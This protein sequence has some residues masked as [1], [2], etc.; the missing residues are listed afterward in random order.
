MKTE[1]WRLDGLFSLYN[2]ENTWSSDQV[3]C[4]KRLLYETLLHLQKD[5]V[6]NLRDW[7]H[8]VRA[9]QASKAYQSISLWCKDP[10]QKCRR[11][12]SHDLWSPEKFLPWRQDQCKVHYRICT[13]EVPKEE[14]PAQKT[15]LRSLCWNCFLK[16]QQHETN[17]VLFKKSLLPERWPL[18]CKF[19]SVDAAPT[20]LE[21][22]MDLWIHQ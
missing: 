14:L 12:I 8:T 6:S 15:L 20:M 22:P 13:I 21:L 5:A 7:I 1:W 10:G 4:F 9:F 11:I 17:R 18:T 3:V 2:L 19:Y 16:Q